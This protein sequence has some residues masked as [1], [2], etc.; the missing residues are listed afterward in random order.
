M[1]QP[2]TGGEGGGLPYIWPYETASAPVEEEEVIA[3]ASQDLLM[4]AIIECKMNI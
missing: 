4:Q 2:D 1:M 3:T